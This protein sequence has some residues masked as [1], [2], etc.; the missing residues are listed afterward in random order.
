MSEKAAPP[1]QVGR[2]FLEVAKGV[3]GYNRE[4]AMQRGDYI[5]MPWGTFRQWHATQPNGEKEDQNTFPTEGS[6]RVSVSRILREEGKSTH[7]IV[8][9]GGIQ[10]NVDASL[11]FNY[12]YDH[13]HDEAKAANSSNDGSLWDERNAG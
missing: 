6:A 10:R 7:A 8:E 9:A 12:D 5:E 1:Q 11:F 13:G 4:Q 2:N 3:K